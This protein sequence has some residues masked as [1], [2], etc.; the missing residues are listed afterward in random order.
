MH[1][2]VAQRLTFVD[3]P[4]MADF[5]HNETLIFNIEL[6]KESIVTNSVLENAYPL[7]AF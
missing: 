4:S 2:S 6:V 1:D 3:F 5:Q 7:S